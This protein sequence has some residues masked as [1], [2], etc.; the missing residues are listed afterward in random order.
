MP[1]AHQSKQVIGKQTHRHIK[2]IDGLRA[3]AVFAVLLYHLG[4][5]WIPGRLSRR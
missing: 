5:N 4:I 1:P 2:P 3:V